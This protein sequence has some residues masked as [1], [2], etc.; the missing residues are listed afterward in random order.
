MKNLLA[1]LLLLTTGFAFAQTTPPRGSSY[2]DSVRA[3]TSSGKTVM[4]NGAP[5][6]SAMDFIE[7][8]TASK[9]HTTFLAA[10][11]AANMVGT[12]KS[13]GPLTLLAPPDSAFKQQLGLRLDTLMK[14]AHK[15]ELINVLSYHIL[16]GE[17]TIKSLTKLI[18]DGHGEASILTLAG[19]KLTARI[20]ENRNIQ[21]TDETGG[22]SV[23]SQFN[24]EE[25]NGLMHL[26]TRVLVPKDKAM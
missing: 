11:R 7:N 24:I 22:K 13:R 6:N 20:D 26:I 25:N 19:S 2:Q 9:T 23:I 4:V 1:L 17:Y 3:S 12:L 21:F 14:P 15:Y 8:L 18:N 10:V 5:V 16:A